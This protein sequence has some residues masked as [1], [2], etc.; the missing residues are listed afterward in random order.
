MLGYALSH[1][2]PFLVLSAAGFPLVMILFF[3]IIRRQ[4][5]AVLVSAISIEIRYAE[6]G[7][8]GLISSFVTFACSPDLYEGIRRACLIENAEERTRLISRLSGKVAFAGSALMKWA[9]F[10]SIAAEVIL[11]VIFWLSP[12][13]WKT[14]VPA[15]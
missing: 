10:L 6:P 5:L 7:T 12:P 2:S 8:Y 13:L 4:I 1:D 14:L 9:T 3:L 15:H 11:P